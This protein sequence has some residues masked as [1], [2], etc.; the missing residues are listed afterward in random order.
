MRI[1]CFSLFYIIV[2]WKSFGFG[3]LVRQN[4]KFEDIVLGPGS[5]ISTRHPP[6]AIKLLAVAGEIIITTLADR[7]NASDG[8]REPVP[9]CLISWHLMPP[10]LSIPLI[11]AFR[12]LGMHN[13]SYACCIMFQFVWDRRHGGEKKKRSTAWRY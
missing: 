1:C 11:D 5:E 7:E 8:N 6:N 2:N 12:Q 9:S 10:C 4:K 13:D 3:L